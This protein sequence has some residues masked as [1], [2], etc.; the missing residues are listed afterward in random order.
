[1]KTI[2]VIDDSDFER[3]VLKKGLQLKGE[4]AIIEANSGAAGLKVLETQQVDL[5]LLDIVMP[6]ATGFDVLLQIR[7]T[8]NQLA[9]PVLMVSAISDD[10]EI[11]SCL[12]N[13]ANDF[14]TKPV[15]FTVAVSRINTH[16]RFAELSIELGKV[17]EKKAIDSMI[18]TYNHEI[19]NPLAIAIG[20]M[21][22]SSL[23]KN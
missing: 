16:I 2:L 21:K 9:L 17:E 3:V 8:F 19:N 4:F 15:N 5:V 22:D 1:M 12:Q 20:F 18:A 6:D 13:G 10:T 23:E 11:V 14:I 7:K